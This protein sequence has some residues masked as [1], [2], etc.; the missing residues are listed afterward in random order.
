[1]KVN[2]LNIRKINNYIN[3]LNKELKEQMEEIS[4]SRGNYND[5]N[6]GIEG[7]TLYLQLNSYMKESVFPCISLAKYAKSSAEKMFF[8]NYLCIL[9]YSFIELYA[10][11]LN[12]YYNLDLIP[13]HKAA[14]RNIINK[15]IVEQ[16]KAGLSNISGK[17][18]SIE[19]V[20]KELNEKYQTNEYFEAIKKILEMDEFRRLRELRHNQ[21]HYQPIF[22]RFN[23]CYIPEN[24][25]FSINISPANADIDEREYHDFFSMSKRIVDGE[26]KLIY[27]FFEMIIDKKMLLKGEEEKEVCV[28][29]CAKCKK[30]LLLPEEF[31]LNMKELGAVLTFPHHEECNG[32]VD[33]EI[34]NKIKVHPEKYNGIKNDVNEWLIGERFN[35]L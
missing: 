5:I 14:N 16:T 30:K 4:I 11:C 18:V 29:R 31:I 34:L 7:T 24:K 3:C 20:I 9:L 15:G 35:K 6:K 21:L 12:A 28:V 23:Q 27:Y 19:K 25:D 10:Q 13:V 32:I 22:G 2:G 26:I 33:W 17:V 1:M 8:C